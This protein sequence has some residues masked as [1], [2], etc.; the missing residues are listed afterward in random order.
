MNPDVERSKTTSSQA[1]RNAERGIPSLPLANITS[2][3]FGGGSAGQYPNAVGEAFSQALGQLTQAIFKSADA[4]HSSRSVSTGRSLP[5]P[6]PPGPATEDVA[7]FAGFAGPDYEAQA[8]AQHAGNAPVTNEVLTARSGRSNTS[9]VMRRDEIANEPAGSR[10]LLVGSS[11]TRPSALELQ[12]M[13]EAIGERCGEDQ[14]EPASAMLQLMTDVLFGAD[15]R[16]QDRSVVALSYVRR[17]T[18]RTLEAIAQRVVQRTGS[19]EKSEAIRELLFQL[20]DSVFGRVDQDDAVLYTAR[21]SVRSQST[22]SEEV[23]EEVNSEVRGIL[24]ELCGVLFTP[25]A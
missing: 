21:S 23:K 9:S 24:T 25:G 8:F 17:P 16:A 22:T 3:S 6:G 7:P 13:A 18:P 20:T 15:Q 2:S 1:E 4:L 19:V 5:W 12:E 11:T 14:V 10:G